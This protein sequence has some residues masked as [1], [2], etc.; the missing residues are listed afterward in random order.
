LF[1]KTLAEQQLLA[2]RLGSLMLQ[3]ISKSDD[4]SACMSQFNEELLIGSLELGAQFEERSPVINPSIGQANDLGTFSEQDLAQPNMETD[5]IDLGVMSLEQTKEE[6]WGSDE[7]SSNGLTYLEGNEGSSIPQDQVVEDPIIA[8]HTGRSIQLSAEDI[9]PKVDYSPL[10]ESGFTRGF[11][12]E[13]PKTK[14]KT[15]ALSTKERII[16]TLETLS[17]PVE[18][19]VPSQLNEAF[20]TIQRLADINRMKT[21]SELDPKLVR[22]LCVFI[23]NYI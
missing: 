3:Q 17:A 19:I 9:K 8:E 10:I 2:L 4:F 20:S 6:M 5:K 11:T 18:V 1:Q 7:L 12:E 13:L 23:V 22:A 15:V 21:W 14:E 16:K